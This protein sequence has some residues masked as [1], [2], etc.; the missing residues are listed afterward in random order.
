MLAGLWTEKSEHLGAWVWPDKY[1]ND[2]ITFLVY[3]TAGRQRRELDA[4]HSR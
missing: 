2:L 4:N 3:L 1:A